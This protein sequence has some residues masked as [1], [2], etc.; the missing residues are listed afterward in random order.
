MD[1]VG[2]QVEPAGGP[3][4]FWT[5]LSQTVSDRPLTSVGDR[6]CPASWSGVAAVV[7]TAAYLA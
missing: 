7:A 1:S 6:R 2:I 4:V 3:R 5:G